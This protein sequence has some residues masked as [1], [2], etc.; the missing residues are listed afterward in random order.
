MCSSLDSTIIRNST[1]LWNSISTGMAEVGKLETYLSVPFTLAPAGFINVFTIALGSYFGTAVES[2][3]LSKSV[4]VIGTLSSSALTLI[5]IPEA[6]LRIVVNTAIS[7]FCALSGRENPLEGNSLLERA[8]R[9]IVCTG[10][11]LINT[12]EEAY[13]AVVN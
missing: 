2:S 12:L 10:A 3:F 9:P 5:A 11:F 1:D 8:L 7:I 4:V 13:E 6:L